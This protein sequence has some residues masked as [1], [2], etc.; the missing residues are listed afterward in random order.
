LQDQD[1]TDATHTPPTG[2]RRH[3]P[4]G[5]FG[6]G[7]APRGCCLR[8]LTASVLCLITTALVFAPAAGA[9]RGHSFQSTIGEPG[10]GAGQMK[11]RATAE[12]A[13][14]SGVA[15]NPTTHEVYVADTGNH[16][17][18]EFQANGVFVRAWGWGVAGGLGFETCTATCKEGLQGTEPGQFTDPTFITIDNSPTGAGDVYVADTNGN[19]ITKFSATGELQEAWG[20]NG[21]ASQSPTGPAEALTPFGP[22]AG[23]TIDPEGTL[24]ILEKEAEQEN[25]HNRLLQY[26][27]AGTFKDFIETPRG[28]HPDGLALDAKGFFYK[29]NGNQTTEQIMPS[30]EDKGQVKK[31]ESVGEIV[32]TGLAFDTGPGAS[33]GGDLY[34]DTGS[35]LE[36]YA[37]NK[38]GEVIEAGGRTCRVEPSVGCEPSETLASANITAAGGAGVAVDTSLSTIYVADAAPTAEHIIVL[39]L[40]PLTVPLIVNETA[41]EVTDDSAV[42]EG[43]IN[44]RTLA[45][46]EGTEY[47]FQY[48]PCPTP[49]ASCAASPYPSS[50]PTGKLLPAYE[51]TAVSASITGL[52]AG[53]TYHYQLIASNGYGPSEGSGNEFTTRGGGEF[54]LPDGRQWEMVSPAAMHGALIEPLGI[55]GISNGAQTQAAAGGGAITYAASVPTE[56]EPVGN[57]EVAQVLSTR[58]PSG[59]S[60][61][62]IA[63][64]HSVAPGVAQNAIE[65]RLF[66]EDLSLAVMQPLGSFIPLSEDASEQ[67][68]YL[69]ENPTGEYTPLVTGCP[70]EPLPCP[71]AIQANADVAPGTIFGQLTLSESP[72]PG[73]FAC[74]PEFIGATPNL[75]HVIL[76]ALAS[77]EPGANQRALYEWNK[78]APPA[79]RLQLIS[80]LPRNEE[81]EERPAENP[82]L[83]FLLVGPEQ[84]GAISEDGT[85]IFFS[86]S[87]HLYMRDTTTHKTIQIDTPCAVV[88]G[89]GPQNPE[90]QIAST[91]GN[92]VFFTDTQKLTE[93]GK[94]YSISPSPREGADLYVCEIREDVCT[95][96]DLTPSGSALG[97]PLGASD[98]GSRVYFAANRALAPGAKAGTCTGVKLEMLP[99]TG[100]ACD[101]YVESF[102]EGGWGQPRVVAAVSGADLSNWSPQL[103]SM[104]SRVSPSGGW[105]AFMSER[106]LTGYDNRD[107]VSGVRD[108]EVFLYDAETGQL[109]CA[110]CDPSG[111]RPHGAEYG[112]SGRNVPLL[113]FGTWLPSTWLAG[114]VPSWVRYKGKE[115][116]Y[117]PRYLGDDG[118]L[119]F[120]AHDAL[121]SK[122]LNRAGDVYEF[123]PVGVPA[124]GGGCSAAGVAGSGGSVFKAERAFEVGGVGGVEGAGCVGLVSSGGSGEESALLDASGSGGDVF[125]I[126]TAKLSP[127]DSEGGLTVYDAHECTS[128]SP[129][130]SVPGAGVGA[131]GTEAS[132]KAAPSVQP[133]IFGPSGSATFKGPGNPAPPAVKHKSAAQV[134]AERLAR[135]LKACHKLKR[136]AKRRACERLAHKRYPARKA[137]VVVRHA[138]GG[139]GAGR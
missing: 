99:G 82:H 58:G 59:W 132:C 110:S 139:R 117:Q 18:D 137:S 8:A 72:C 68:A 102:T 98:D 112:I 80:Q 75:N 95:L 138:A 36:R 130:I 124:G 101:L 76:T 63:V 86:A 27:Q 114:S 40:E 31:K 20:T 42:L 33:A 1:A 9:A 16:R 30:G 127:L 28:S 14:G 94:A 32:T 26:T 106:P 71:S 2:T 78:Q 56:A 19:I 105:L 118:R 100:E 134:R 55:G 73:T 119:F 109:D 52:Q 44:P 11:L 23:I 35:E 15:V 88:C 37:F 50:T 17:V 93:D 125:F 38:E 25:T 91:G 12:Q 54:K 107:A 24:D 6:G 85:H 69:R 131:C 7:L 84:R 46:E 126:S 122:D 45:G 89:G 104:V 51:L 97:S 48:G 53:G 128:A 83:G 115:A 108:Q 121:V 43:E 120:D 129:C 113:G 41:S 3:A 5:L 133:S 116:I 39:A 49:P 34:V 123:E 4:D 67:T 87:N 29:A 103:E 79:A 65:T 13:A 66:S 60:S 64:P 22:L 92:R 10:S 90:F 136:H 57:V 70:T 111:A 62:D 74:G 47:H 135:A 77:L 61:T 96:T 21:Q 81:G